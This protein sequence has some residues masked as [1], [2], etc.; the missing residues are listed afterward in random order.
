MAA[1]CAPAISEYTLACSRPK[2]PAPI[3]AT[4]II[5]WLSSYRRASEQHLD[6]LSLA[7]YTQKSD[8][9]ARF[10]STQQSTTEQKIIVEPQ[11]A[12]KQRLYG[13]IAI[14]AA[15]A[16]TFFFG[17]GRIGFLGPDE[18][19]YAEVAREMFASGDYIS[20]RLCGCL[21]F[22]KPA[23]LYWM[24]A[25]GYHFFGVDELAARIP[26]AV[27]AIGTV[28]LLYF[29]L[30]SISLPRLA[31][32]AAL[33]LSTS[34]IFIAYARVAVPDMSLTTSITGALLS[35]MLWTR[36]AGRKRTFYLL[37]SFAL[38]GLATL[39]KGLVGIVLVLAIFAIYLF[40][41]GR[42]REARW[43]E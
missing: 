20:T 11:P 14:L 8:I 13:F 18:P 32:S 29:A 1:R 4:S 40:F 9:R 25:A 2:A 5:L 41:A 6:P 33:V 24:S 26:S 39:A 27:A 30:R 17:L 36:S 15:S 42:L 10:N 16:F 31:L 28:A 21:W 23:L 3:T 22:E 38:V 12:A 37:L 19:R 35:A 43:R 7:T 34:G